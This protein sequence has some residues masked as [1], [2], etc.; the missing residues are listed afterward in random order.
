M[1]PLFYSRHHIPS[2][3]RN[4]EA[5]T[6]ASLHP[7][8][9]ISI[10]TF[11]YP[12]SHP[13]SY[14]PFVQPVPCIHL[15]SP[16]SLPSPPP[17][18][19][20][21]I[22]DP[23]SRRLSIEPF[24]LH[25]LPSPTASSSPILSVSPAICQTRG[26]VQGPSGFPVAPRK[27]HP[28][29]SKIPSE[30][31]TWGSSEEILDGSPPQAP[32]PRPSSQKTETGIFPW[33]TTLLR[34]HPPFQ[35]RPRYTHT[36]S[37][38][39]RCSHTHTLAFRLVLVSLHKHSR[40]LARTR[41]GSY[42]SVPSLRVPTRLVLVQPTTNRPG[43][44]RLRAALARSSWSRCSLR[45]LTPQGQLWDS[46]AG[47]ARQPATARLLLSCRLSPS[48]RPS[49]LA[50]VFLGP[51]YHPPPV[52]AIA[53]ADT[54]QKRNSDLP[55][56]LLFCL[57]CRHLAP[58]NLL[59]NHP[60]PPSCP[61]A[62]HPWHRGSSLLFPWS[63]PPPPLVFLGRRPFFPWFF[64]R[65]YRASIPFAHAPA[66]RPT[67]SSTSSSSASHPPCPPLLP[68]R[69]VCSWP[70]LVRTRLPSRLARRPS[71]RLLVPHA[72]LVDPLPALCAAEHLIPVV[73]ISRKRR[74]KTPCFSNGM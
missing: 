24:T 68:N 6:F 47:P 52:L 14:Y 54:G 2:R 58:F 11:L 31:A 20:A 30:H 29:P 9:L 59:H 66:R 57:F 56:Y 62:F 25:A 18:R 41:T 46:P 3:W 1:M 63:C 38:T 48:S 33:P 23:S 5:L 10:L 60:P 34:P 37:H 13:Y 21:P 73:R 42:R 65:V 15:S 26:P 50:P 71:P 67:S 53:T 8:T 51:R 7:S 55:T 35:A 49:L 28:K 19:L 64:F 72:P 70:A 22:A 40:S 27:A 39:A 44:A 17:T 16:P 74:P 36:R 4:Q 32:G 61:P 69:P 12:S 45:S 43:P